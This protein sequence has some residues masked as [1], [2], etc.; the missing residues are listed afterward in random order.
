MDHLPFKKD[1]WCMFFCFF[2]YI[3][4]ILPNGKHTHTHTHTHTHLAE[5][6]PFLCPV[7]SRSQ[8]LT[9][10]LFPLRFLYLSP[11]LSPS[12]FLYP[13]LSPP[14]LSLSLSLSPCTPPVVNQ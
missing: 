10:P 3:Q 13:S 11:L 1:S 6:A 14:S 4:T 2:S 8:Q 9:R 5:P 7:L 12:L